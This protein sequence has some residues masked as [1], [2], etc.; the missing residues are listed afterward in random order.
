MRAFRSKRL[1]TAGF[2]LLGN[3]FTC[4]TI[5]FYLFY[6]HVSSSFNNSFFVSQFRSD[7]RIRDLVES[8]LLSCWF[9]MFWERQSLHTQRNKHNLPH[10]TWSNYFWL[11]RIITTQKIKPILIPHYMTP[12]KITHTFLFRCIK[13]IMWPWSTKAVISN[14]GI[15]VAIDNNT[16]YESKL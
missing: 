6:I 2:R 14:T 11:V 10:M 15:F 5:R 9:V 4:K 3:I 8:T 12:F 7:W 1:R 13:M 16:L